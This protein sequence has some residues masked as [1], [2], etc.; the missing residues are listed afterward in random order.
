MLPRLLVKRRVNNNKYRWDRLWLFYL[1]GGY[2]NDH[3]SDGLYVYL[4]I[5]DTGCGI[6]EEI[7]INLWALFQYEIPE[8]GLGLT[9]VLS[10][11]R[12]HQGGIKLRVKKKKEVI[13]P[14]YSSGKQSGIRLDNWN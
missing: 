12:S 10:I 11:V 5:T 7:R 2:M 1:A 4:E 6:T 14:Y 9:I 13:L 3:L 8:R